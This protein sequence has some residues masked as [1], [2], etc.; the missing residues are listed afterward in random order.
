MGISIEELKYYPIREIEYDR[1]FKSIQPNGVSLTQEQLKE[2]ISI[3]DEK[4]SLNSEGLS[5]IYDG[6]KR[7]DEGS[8]ELYKVI[9]VIYAGLFYGLQTTSDCMVAT[10]CY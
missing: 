10:K 1:W 2:M 9:N 4:V 6:Y 3:I 5:M 8:S 7:S